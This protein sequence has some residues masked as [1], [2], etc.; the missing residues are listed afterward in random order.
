MRYRIILPNTAVR[1]EMTAQDLLP[2]LRQFHKTGTWAH[3]EA[4]VEYG[5]GS[6]RTPAFS[7]Q[8]AVRT[9]LSQKK[10]R[11]KKNRRLR[12]IPHPPDE[13]IRHLFEKSVEGTSGKT[14]TE[15][16]QY[17]KGYISEGP[18]IHTNTAEKLLQLNRLRKAS[19]RFHIQKILRGWPY[20]YVP[21]HRGGTQK[22]Y[23]LRNPSIDK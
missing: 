16:F 7:E 9:G 13:A 17:L 21:Q 5:P 22:K 2:V 6:K 19:I 12:P 10:N 15:F 20:A 18:T 4:Y 23:L 11:T 8:A 3:I 1:V 14:I